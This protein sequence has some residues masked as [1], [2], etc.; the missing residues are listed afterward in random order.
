[1]VEGNVYITAG[2]G[3]GTVIFDGVTVKGAVYV[4]AEGVTVNFNNSQINAVN[5]ISSATV[6]STNG[7]V[8]TVY[9]PGG[10]PSGEKTFTLV[11]RFDN[12]LID[13]FENLF[14]IKGEVPSKLIYD[15]ADLKSP[16]FYDPVAVRARIEAM[17][18]SYPNGMHFTNESHVTTWN[19]W[20]RREGGEYQRFRYTA[21]GCV[22][23][24]VFM[25][26][27]AFGNDAWVTEHKNF[28]N[29]RVGDILRVEDGKHSVVVLAI[30]GNIVT[31]AEGNYNHS[32]LWGR[33]YTLEQI[34]SHG[35]YVWTRY[36]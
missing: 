7:R 29:I 26:D 21:A 28:D 22:A 19:I 18:P 15:E 25:S 36:P 12:V 23:F 2:V 32:V 10:S 27:A 3:D 4:A 31:I 13:T 1:M 17:K 14:G 5:M 6:S 33:T 34:K 9:V 30:D 24:A 20:F 8:V 16:D 35:T 11:G